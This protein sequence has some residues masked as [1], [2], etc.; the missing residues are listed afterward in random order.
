M[1]NK[2]LILFSSL[3]TGGMQTGPRSIACRQA[4]AALGLDHAFDGHAV[5]Y[6]SRVNHNGSIHGS[7][8]GRKDNNAIL[9]VSKGAVVSN[10]HKKLRDEL[11]RNNK[12][13]NRATHRLQVKSRTINALESSSNT[14]SVG[15][16]I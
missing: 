6:C 9:R 16:V 10:S 15:P 2:T 7:A 12:T 4:F 1:P 14:T 3:I 11:G 5:P 8:G 13:P